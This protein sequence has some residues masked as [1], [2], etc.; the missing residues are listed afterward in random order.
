MVAKRSWLILGICLPAALFT[1]CQREKAEAR[2][3]QELKSG[4]YEAAINFYE[5][6]L[7][8]GN[9]AAIHKK[10]AEIFSSKLKDP[11]S[12]A[13]HYHRIAALNAPNNKAEPVRSENRKPDSPV[14]ADAAQVKSGPPLKPLPPPSQAAAE[15]ERQG[16][17][18]AR[19]YVVQPGDS[20]SSIS[21]KF[22]QSSSRW[23]DILDAN[24]NQLSNPDE[25]KAGQTIILP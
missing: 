8:E 11:A 13:Y 21:R 16:K 19:T 7:G 4:H 25:L 22:Y 12:A 23:K 10:M 3:D 5:A 14:P 2:G 18:K 1:G 9:R 20:L 17:S 24:Q 6:A 15:G